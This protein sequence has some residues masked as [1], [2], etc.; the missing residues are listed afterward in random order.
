M[1][2]MQIH[3]T[4]MPEADPIERSKCFEEVARGYT[5]EQAINEAKRCL[6][7]KTRPCVSGCPVGVKIPE[8]IAKIKEGEFEEAY[9]IIAKTSS[10]PALHGRWQIGAIA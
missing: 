3:K 9:R 5:E 1:A 2:N 7:C 10:L 4:P 8:F 6:N